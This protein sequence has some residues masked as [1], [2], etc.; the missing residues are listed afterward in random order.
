VNKRLTSLKHVGWQNSLKI[1]Y[2]FKNTTDKLKWENCKDNRIRETC[3]T[4]IFVW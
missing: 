1:R 3:Q 4:Q 2:T